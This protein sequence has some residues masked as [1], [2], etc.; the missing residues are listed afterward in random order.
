MHASEDCNPA[1]AGLLDYNIILRK[2]CLHYIHFGF[3]LFNIG[4]AVLALDILMKHIFKDSFIQKKSRSKTVSQHRQ[5][6]SKRNDWD[7]L[8]N[9]IPYL[10]ENSKIRLKWIKMLLV[11]Q[12]SLQIHFLLLIIKI[13]CSSQCILSP[14]WIY[15]RETGL[16]R[17]KM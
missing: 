9:R 6:Y 13:Y 17:P 1:W 4:P 16:Y 3:S 15:K 12:Y 8:Q 7:W 10:N 11:L 14:V 2:P 5:K